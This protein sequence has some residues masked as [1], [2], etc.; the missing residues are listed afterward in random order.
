MD[1]VA[2]L[3]DMP[4]RYLCFGKEVS[5]SGTP[6]LQG[7]IVFS[8]AKTLSAAIKCFRPLGA[9]VEI[10]R[11]S[12]QQNISYCSKE[13][14]FLELGDRPITQLEKGALESERWDLALASAKSGNIDDIPS[15]IFFRYYRTVKE[16]KKD[17]MVTPE[18]IPLV[19]GVW[20]TGLTGCGKSHYARDNY[21]GAYK[22]M[23]NKWWDGYQSQEY[24]IID[25]LDK[26]HDC[27]GHH[28]KI[29]CDRYSFLAETKGGAINIRPLKII[30]TSQYEIDDIW[31]DEETR[32]ALHRRMEV[33]RMKNRKVVTDF[34]IFEPPTA[35]ASSFIPPNVILPPRK[36]PLVFKPVNN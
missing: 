17:Y 36:N 19:S 31:P 29:W 12:V 7:F 18:D 11:G 34:P 4:H 35:I 15:D 20:I 3:S 1:N 33:I 5:L 14:D 21:P 23:A 28:L 24:V 6:H 13:G 2:V 30:I 22:K 10:A 32:G 9:H 16:I 27:L 25:E 26:K 8:S